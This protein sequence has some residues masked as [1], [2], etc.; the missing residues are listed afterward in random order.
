MGNKNKKGLNILKK[1]KVDFQKKNE[2]VRKKI[3]E[4]LPEV[5]EGEKKE[6]KKFEKE[7]FESS[8]NDP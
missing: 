7:A 2:E 8:K 3:L 4:N 6:F 5:D 1:W